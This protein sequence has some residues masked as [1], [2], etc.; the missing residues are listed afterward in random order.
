MTTAPEPSSSRAVGAEVRGPTDGLCT[1]TKA[2]SM[3]AP[4][5]GWT[6]FNLSGT[7]QISA[8]KARGA[9]GEQLPVPLG[10]DFDGAVGHLDGGLV[11]D[12][13]RPARHP[14]GPFVRI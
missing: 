8:A 1:R 5:P 12:R 7:T 3:T 14:G 2:E 9:R 13:I 4:S 6:V 11:V 10:N